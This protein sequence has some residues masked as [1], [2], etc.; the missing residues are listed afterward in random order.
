MCAAAGSRT[1]AVEHGATEL[2]KQLP[3]ALLGLDTDNDTAF[4]NEKLKA[5][6]DAANVVFTRCRPYRKN[7]QAF[8]EQKNDAVGRR[9]VGCRSRSSPGAA[10]RANRPLRCSKILLPLCRR[11]WRRRNL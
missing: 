10:K 3:F 7:D 5:Y 8:V 4:M 11:F 1:D 6:C 2:R 9:M